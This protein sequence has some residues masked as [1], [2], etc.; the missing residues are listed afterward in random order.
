MSLRYPLAAL[1][2]FAAIFAGAL[3]KSG[4]PPAHVPTTV[5]ATAT[6]LTGPSGL[7]VPRFVA[8]KKNRVVAR[9]GPS[10]DYPVA[11]E[12]NRAGLPLKVIAE[13]RD[14]IWRRVEDRDGQRMWI[15]RSMLAPNEHAVVMS[16]GVILRAAPRTDGQPR[17]RI[18]GGVLMRL[19]TCTNGWCRLRT[20]DFRGWLPADALWGA[21]I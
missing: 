18:A 5:A 17:A 1:A 19:E 2:I 16:D 7:P 6:T 21:S 4:P 10:F 3:G 9:F 20:E 8:L 15:H 11:Y 12:F 14:N 13:D